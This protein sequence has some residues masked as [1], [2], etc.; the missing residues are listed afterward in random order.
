MVDYEAHNITPWEQRARSLSPDRPLAEK[1]RVSVRAYSRIY[2]SGDPEATDSIM[3]PDVIGVGPSPIAALRHHWLGPH[4][5]REQS[6]TCVPGFGRSAA[7]PHLLHASGQHVFDPFACSVQS[8]CICRHSRFLLVLQRCLSRHL[9]AW[10]IWQYMLHMLRCGIHRTA[11][12]WALK[13]LVDGGHLTNLPIQGHFTRDAPT[14]LQQS[15]T[16]LTLR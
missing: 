2:E 7:G 5:T 1:V 16:H 10:S 14:I 13:H 15:D 3:V 11:T 9:L 4:I 6:H 8:P 12:R